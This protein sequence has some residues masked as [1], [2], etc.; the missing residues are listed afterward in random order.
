M[1]E[2]FLSEH[3]S[4]QMLALMLLV[5]VMYACGSCK[6]DDCVGNAVGFRYF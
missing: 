5:L 4:A 1:D 6:F 2:E 3:E